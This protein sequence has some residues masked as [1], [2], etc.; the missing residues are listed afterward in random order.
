MAHVRG[1][2][3]VRRAVLKREASADA[4]LDDGP[5]LS[6]AEFLSLVFA[7]EREQMRREAPLI[8]RIESRQRA[9]ENVFKGL[10]EEGA[11]DAWA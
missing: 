9:W 6:T 2:A 11:F 4:L 10:A 1:G 5:R 7:M 8:E 3:R